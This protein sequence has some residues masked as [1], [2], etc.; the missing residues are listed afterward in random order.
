[1]ES[2]HPTWVRLGVPVRNHHNFTQP[3]LL[4][5]DPAGRLGGGLPVFTFLFLFTPPPQCEFEIKETHVTHAEWVM[6]LFNFNPQN[7]CNVS[8]SL[9][10]SPCRFSLCFWLILFGP[11]WFEQVC[12]LE[13][14][15]G[16]SNPAVVRDGR[17]H[18]RPGHFFPG[19]RT[20]ADC[21]AAR[22]EH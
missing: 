1:M 19:R 3:F 12:G 15:T 4:S 20:Q 21:S 22:M 16:T 2:S 13:R 17:T 9:S 8:A 14:A 10:G 7:G 18:F 6:A 11:L 5:L